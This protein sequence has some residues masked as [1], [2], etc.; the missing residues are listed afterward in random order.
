MLCFKL[1]KASDIEINFDICSLRHLT[2]INSDLVR[3]R[4]M[5]REM[6]FYLPTIMP[7]VKFLNVCQRFHVHDL[8]SFF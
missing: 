8:K 3:I 5:A 2:Q 7:R 1:R 6:V 4:Y